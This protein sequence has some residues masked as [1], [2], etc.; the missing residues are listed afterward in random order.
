[1]EPG[2]RHTICTQNWGLT[3]EPQLLPSCWGT[4]PVEQRTAPGLAWA[5]SGTPMFGHGAPA[6]ER[7][8]NSDRDI[9]S[10]HPRVPHQHAPSTGAGV[11]LKP[12]P[13]SMTCLAL[14]WPRPHGTEGPSAVPRGPAVGGAAA[15]QPR[16]LS[17]SL[18]RWG[19]PASPP[20]WG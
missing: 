15:P 7:M 8:G 13:V 20:G 4:G 19:V 5:A 2:A 3:A 9:P 11:A 17:R 6:S 16:H 14:V 12:V 1:M 10:W 18:L